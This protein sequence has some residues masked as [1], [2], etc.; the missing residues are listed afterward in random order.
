[1]TRP[2]P[3]PAAFLGR[4]ASLLGEEYPAFLTSLNERPLSALRV[5]TLKLSAEVFRS[6]APFPLGE[7]VGWC[8]SAFLL[9]PEAQERAGRHPYHRTG[10][11]YLQDPS[12][13][14][15][16]ELLAPQPGERVLD[17]A[18]SPGGKTTH[19]ASLMAGQGLLFANEIKT[20]RLGHLCQNV[21]RW[22]AANVI[23]TN[24]TPERLADCFGEY[25]DRVLVD[26]PC[27]GE[28]MFRKDQ[29][30][31]G[32]WSP[33]MV[34]GCAIRQ[35]RIL[36]LAAKLVRPGGY[37]LY[38]TCTFSPEENEAVIYALLQEY[39]ALFE[40]VELP[41]LPGFTPG[42][43]EWAC[44]EAA[45]KMRQ[46]LQG[47]VRLF[48]HRLAGEGH[49]VCLLRKRQEA[50]P[51]RI[52]PQRGKKPDASPP[53]RHLEAWHEF[54]SSTLTISFPEEHL[55][56]Y[57]ERLYLVSPRLPPLTNLR[58]VHPGLW[59]GVIQAERFRPA[60]P[61][62]LFL[63][64]YQVNQVYDLP[65]HSPE[66]KA[67]LRG[68]NL[69]SPGAEGWVLVTVD[70]WPLGWARRVQGI[71]KNHYPRGWLSVRGKN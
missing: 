67:Y 54:V 7:R 56:L 49:F 45:P 35:R 23:I 5:N 19:L 32:E 34:A 42:H 68:E 52:F 47:S 41:L 17:L 61:L 43:L 10:L 71:L 6:L 11:Y 64:P 26:A 39:P 65:S 63:R 30:A 20:S 31:R 44:P 13:M 70:G 66:L 22:G 25:F 38:S 55:R 28:G 69:P 36:S 62:A 40:V 21:E 51:P 60:H 37:L 14:A 29:R 12:A 18:A 3:L 58:V 9:P 27:S 24:E 2:I 16:A 57:G 8:P 53:R 48:P 46:A 50:S 15:P 33:R 1:M 59:L 4:M